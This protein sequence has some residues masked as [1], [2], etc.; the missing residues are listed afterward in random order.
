MNTY[1][2]IE[3]N[4]DNTVQLSSICRGEWCRM[5]ESEM[6]TLDHEFHDYLKSGKVNEKFCLA[7]ISKKMRQ[8]YRNLSPDIHI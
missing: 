2:E 3:Q 6:D 8:G 7:T 4:I 1:K 5:L